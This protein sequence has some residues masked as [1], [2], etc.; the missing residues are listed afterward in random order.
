MS[1][2]HRFV[3]A[4]SPLRTLTNPLDFAPRIFACFPRSTEQTRYMPRL[5]RRPHPPPPSPICRGE[6]PSAIWRGGGEVEARATCTQ[7]VHI[8]AIPEDRWLRTDPG[9]AMTNSANAKSRVDP[10]SPSPNWRAKLGKLERGAGGEVSAARTKT[11]GS[12]SDN[13]C[14]CD[15]EQ[16]KAG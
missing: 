12:V 6:Y 15:V 16:G 14:P 2:C 4:S 5:P 1:L 13:P 11:S 8:S 3:C 7:I 10:S 9:I